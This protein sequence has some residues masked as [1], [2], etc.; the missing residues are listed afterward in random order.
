[1]PGKIIPWQ[2]NTDH[3]IKLANVMATNDSISLVVNRDRLKGN[4]AS[5][6]LF[7][8]HGE[9]VSELVNKE[10]QHYNVRLEAKSIKFEALNPDA[11][12]AYVG[13]KSIIIP[14]ARDLKDTNFA[15]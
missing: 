9:L 1:M 11:K 13:L 6:S 10:Y 5:G 15:C 2:N 7:L 4:S 12:D 8:D 3:S 14:N